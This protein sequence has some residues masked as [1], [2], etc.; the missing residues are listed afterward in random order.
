M[1]ELTKLLT[2]IELAADD[3]IDTKQQLISSDARR[4]KT[5]EALSS[6]EALKKENPNQIRRNWVCLGDM[7]IRLGSNE[8]RNLIYEDKYQTEIGIEKL[9]DELH[10]KV[11]KLRQLEGKPELTGFKLKPLDRKEI[12]ALRTGF[13]I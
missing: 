11:D 10:V 4:H 1:E 12:L 5:R 7:F 9:R 6:L 8:T 13:K 2:K 3:I